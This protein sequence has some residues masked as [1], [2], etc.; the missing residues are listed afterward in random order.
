MYVSDCMTQ[1]MLKMI[2]VNDGLHFLPKVLAINV[3]QY[4][5]KGGHDRHIDPQIHTSS[6][7]KYRRV[8]CVMKVLM[9]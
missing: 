5:R 3:C 1:M 8:D 9:L 7:A 4:E 2:N 6:V